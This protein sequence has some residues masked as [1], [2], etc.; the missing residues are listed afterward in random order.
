M[1][2]FATSTSP[3]VYEPYEEPDEER[4]ETM[5][6]NLSARKS[7]Y[8]DALKAVPLIWFYFLMGLIWAIV[9]VG[10]VFS[11]K[12][13][14]FLDYDG[15][16]PTSQYFPLLLIALQ[17]AGA[18]FIFELFFTKGPKWLRATVAGATAVLS[19]VMILGFI[20]HATSVELAMEAGVVEATNLSVTG[21]A[22]VAGAIA[23]E[24]A[25]EPYAT[26]IQRYAAIGLLLSHLSFLVVPVI[27]GMLLAKGWAMLLDLRV[28]R[29]EFE[30]LR[31]TSETFEREDAEYQLATKKL[32]AFSDESKVRALLIAE[33]LA[34]QQEASTK[35]KNAEDAVIARNAVTVNDEQADGET[36]PLG[37]FN[38][39][40]SIEDPDYVEAM[41]REAAAYDDIEVVQAAFDDWKRL[42]FGDGPVVPIR[43]AA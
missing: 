16:L 37:A 19:V 28:A 12:M 15:L 38:R 29:S 25:G 39:A 33:C 27:V 31:E 34:D 30:S 7:A 21:L 41:T 5:A 9:D 22:G 20:V 23:G 36:V 17:F 8:F 35:R 26:M 4:R 2:D 43:P 10:M 40:W 6:E 1:T 11:N 24:V 3:L 14:P 18:V 42:V 13:I 32:A